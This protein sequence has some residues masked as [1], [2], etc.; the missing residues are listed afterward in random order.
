MSEFHKKKLTIDHFVKV[1]E[2]HN[3][4]NSVILSAQKETII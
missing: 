4:L 3:K 1:S 2:I